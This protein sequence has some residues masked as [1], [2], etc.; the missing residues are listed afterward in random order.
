MV[1]TSESAYDFV[2]VG[3]GINS[4]ICAALLAKSG[5]SV[6]VLERNDRPGGCIRSE[7]LT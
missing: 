6:V 2:I 4:L 3:S 5:K 7:E 1:A